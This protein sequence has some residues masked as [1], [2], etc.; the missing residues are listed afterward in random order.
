MPSIVRSVSTPLHGLIRANNRL[1]SYLPIGDNFVQID[2]LKD[3]ESKIVVDH[4][5]EEEFIPCSSLTCRLRSETCVLVPKESL[6]AWKIWMST[7]NDVSVT[8]TALIAAAR[9]G[10]KPT[11]M[12]RSTARCDDFSLSYSK[13]GARRRS[14][15]RLQARRRGE[16]VRVRY[17]PV[18]ISRISHTRD[19]F[20]RIYGYC[21]K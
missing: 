4:V 2:K 14:S 3:V 16:L 7:E 17:P 1:P 18:S 8:A 15:P 12:R 19:H 20:S 11:R 13:A 5:A 21:L 9:L 6:S 10:A